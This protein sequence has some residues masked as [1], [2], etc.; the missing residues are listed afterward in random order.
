MYLSEFGSILR[1]IKPGRIHRWVVVKIT[2]NDRR[3]RMLE[4]H[5]T[6]KEKKEEEKETENKKRYMDRCRNGGDSRSIRIYK[7]ARNR[8]FI[9]SIIRKKIIG[10]YYQH[11]EHRL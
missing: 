1:L 5:I 4:M 11:L 3:R 6:C 2:Q 8:I 9:F 10:H 7:K